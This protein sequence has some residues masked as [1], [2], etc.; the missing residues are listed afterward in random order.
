MSPAADS[1]SSAEYRL[2]C[3]ALFR[4]LGQAAATAPNEALELLYY[5]VWFPQLAGRPNLARGRP[6]AVAGAILTDCEQ[7]VDAETARLLPN[8]LAELHALCN[9]PEADVRRGVELILNVHLERRGF[10]LEETW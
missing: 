1:P 10:R 8:L 7:L 2:R 5:P 9:D 3:R 6:T 4:Q